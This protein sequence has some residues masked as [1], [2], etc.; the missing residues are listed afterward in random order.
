MRFREAAIEKQLIAIV[1]IQADYLAV[2]KR[3]IDELRAFDRRIREVTS[4]KSAILEDGTRQIR[5]GQVAA[6]NFT[7]IEFLPW[8]G[9]AG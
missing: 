9:S 2:E 7:A 1:E 5:L 3:D 4:R 6:F 8:D